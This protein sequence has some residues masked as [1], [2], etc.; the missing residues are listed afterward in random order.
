MLALLGF[1]LA[2]QVL[3]WAADV[4]I[5]DYLGDRQFSR[6]F[7][8]EPLVVTGALALALV[9]VAFRYW[10]AHAARYRGPR[11]MA[12]AETDEDT[13]RI[14]CRLDELLTAKAMTLTH[15]SELV[16]RQHREPLGAQERP[17][18]RDPVL[19]AHRD[20]RGSGMRRRRPS[21]GRPSI[22]SV[23]FP[24]MTPETGGMSP[25]E[26]CQLRLM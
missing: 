7:T 3:D 23:P 24:G 6:A 5:L 8:F 13:G 20:L 10:H 21:G 12:P 19:D 18:P 11:L 2:A 4:A 17:G 1:G 15:L 22:V 16:G 25:P 9:A 26:L 14:H